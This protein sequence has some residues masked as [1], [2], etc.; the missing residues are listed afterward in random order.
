MS[1]RSIFLL[2]AL[3][4]ILVASAASVAA[5]VTTVTISGNVNDTAGAV[6]PNAQVT[7]I[8]TET[9]FSRSA[10]TDSSGQYS[11]QFL[12]IG[13]YRIEVTA[14]GFK[15][16]VRSGIVLEVNRNARIDPALEAGAV[17]ETVSITSDAPL[18][19]T[20][21]ATLGQTTTNAEIV[22]LPL[23]N[24]DVYTLLELTAG[25]DSTLNN[26]IFGAPAQV[27]TVNGSPNNGGGT[28]NYYLDGG[29][30]TNGL[31]NTGNSLP[32]PDAVQEFRVITNSY[33]AE[34]G[35]FA[36]GVVDVVS[37]SGTNQWRGSLFEF[38]RNDV[39]NANRWT[40]GISILQKEALRRNQF[41]GTFGGPVI[42]DKT[43]FFASYSGLRQ[44]RPVFKNTATPTTDAER[45]GIFSG[46]IRDP[47]R[48][49]ACTATDQT[50]CFRDPSRATAENPLGLNII[51]LDRYDDTAER[52][53]NE[54]IPRP[55]LPNGAFE[56][57]ESR[58]LD[59]DE[60]LFKV[61]HA[62]SAKHQLTG[63]YFFQKGKD[64]EPMT[65]ATNLPWV[66][67]EFTWKQ[68]NINLGDTWTIGPTMINQFRV[69]YV[70]LFGGRLNTP[71]RSLGDFRLDVQCAGA[72]DAAADSGVRALQPQRRH[73]R[74]G[75][76]QQP[77]S[78]ARCLQLDA[79][80]PLAQIRR[81]GFARKNDPG[82]DA[83]QLRDLQFQQQQHARHWQ[84][85]GRLPARLA[86]DLQPGRAD[87]QD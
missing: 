32:N 65:G 58:P 25:V 9:N 14:T 84:R 53:L 38:I 78:S 87:N 22:N 37:K 5:Q 83:Q 39:L 20:S 51:P 31:R 64:I 8:N 63:S 16:Y 23:V 40:P 68:H 70:R 72:A 82:H 67:R 61:D 27:T 6:I 44:V 50:A 77:L 28:V 29:S 33:S 12:P 18:V 79:R 45:I 56:A 24:R 15:K 75:G 60:I 21:N 52:I 76:G 34:Y 57:Q 86:G 42:R 1:K 69:T 48:T 2:F 36:G 35:R 46:R 26:N 7:A 73:R 11:I 49:G 71:E 3:L 81:R 54:Y 19:E 4:S 13:L 55:N 74:A 41:G 62:L 85:D 43:F 30:N 59:T 17:T 80:Q 66:K 10:T 47:Q